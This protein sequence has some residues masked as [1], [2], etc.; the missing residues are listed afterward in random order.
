MQTS[1]RPPPD[2]RAA[3][4]P[5]RGVLD[6]VTS[7]WGMLVLIVLRDGTLRFS[8]L[9]ASVGGVSEKMLA[10]TLK[11]LEADGFLERRAYPV[12]PPRVEYSLTP[13]GAEVSRHL[14]VL[15][16]WIEANLGRVEAARKRRQ[17]AASRAALRT[18]PL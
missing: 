9:R 7:R 1:K 5:S 3:Q 2:L 12:V 10:Q 11:T 16:S 14:A 15:G 8:E 17:A 6:H 4:C 18:V 13:L